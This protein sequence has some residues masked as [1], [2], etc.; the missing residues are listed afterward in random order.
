MIPLRGPVKRVQQV[1]SSLIS[2][3]GV[4]YGQ[5]VPATTGKHLV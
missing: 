1:A 4:R 2:V 3:K 5:L